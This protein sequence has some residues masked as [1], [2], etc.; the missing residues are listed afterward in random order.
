MGE[1]GEDFDP[2]EAAMQDDVKEGNEVM[3]FDWDML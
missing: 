1:T 3:V 2:D